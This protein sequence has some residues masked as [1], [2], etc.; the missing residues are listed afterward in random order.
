M[1]HSTRTILIVEDQ[2]IVFMAER[3]LL[4]AEGY[5]VVH[6][7][8]AEAAVDEVKHG[9]NIDL[10]LM[11]ISLRGEMDGIEAAERI[12]SFRDIPLMFLSSHVEPEIVARAERVTSY[13]YIVK[14]TSDTVLLASIRM[15]F[16]LFDARQEAAR[17][18]RELRQAGQK[19]VAFLQAVLDAIPATVAVIDESG[20]IAAV[21]ESWRRFAR[22]NGLSWEDF[23]VG[24]A[25]LRPLAEVDGDSLEEAQAC[26]DLVGR[27]IEG[28]QEEASFIMPCHGEHEKR[29][30]LS[31]ARAF[32]HDGR[33]WVVVS[34][35][36]ITGEV[37]A[38]R[39]A[40]RLLGEREL[41]LK[42][43]HHRV[44]NHLSA[45]SGLLSIEALQADG[46][47]TRSA[48]QD[49]S[50]RT[51]S[52]SLLYD[53]LYHGAEGETVN[54]REYLEPLIEGTLE[55]LVSEGAIT[56]STEICDVRLDSTVLVPLGLILSELVTNSV[57]YAFPA[58]HGEKNIHI[59]LKIN[60]SG[61]RFDYSDT[62]VGMS[63]EAGSC[64]SS[65]FGTQLIRMLTEQ[66][67]G[68]VNVSSGSSGTTYTIELP[69]ESGRSACPAR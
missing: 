50:S 63:N 17:K 16:R 57:K 23:G 58:G 8:S 47:Q 66:M 21:N 61:L 65:R 5:E 35:A 64:E 18:D 49:A 44:K 68:T 9:E 54:A 69:L 27:V 6:A 7:A 22:D 14:G 25:Y 12:L 36:S 56:S 45:L 29:W 15:A 42:E 31:E 37:E 48:L 1:P 52:M 38:R 39:R 10:V 62:G 32:E 53:K 24:K 43:T 11:D 4:E 46:E 28:E 19:S 41:L 30:F 33:R 3:M 40:T 26:Q 51:R 13:G 60:D 67:G 2:Y 20:S 55:L 34:H 59:G